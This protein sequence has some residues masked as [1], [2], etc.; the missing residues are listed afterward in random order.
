VGKPDDD[1]EGVSLGVRSA[2]QLVVLRAAEETVR[3][4]DH[5]GARAGDDVGCLVP[6]V[7][8]VDG[9]EG[10]AGVGDCEC[11]DLPAPGVRRPDADPVTTADAEG[12]ERTRRAAYLLVQLCIGQPGV[13]VDD[14]LP[15][16]VRA[17]R[18]A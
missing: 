6:G 9:C 8:G 18:G 7:A 15:V 14:S 4:G 12:D 11:E 3:N 1:R 10:A 16:G 17:R 2:H 5:L 13:A